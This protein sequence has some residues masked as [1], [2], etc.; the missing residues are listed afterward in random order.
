MIIWLASYPKSGNTWVRS[1]I[2][3]LAYSNDGKF[4]MK[5]LSQIHQFPRISQLKDIDKFMKKNGFKAV[6]KSCFKRHETG[7]YYDVLYEKNKIN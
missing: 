5:L 2:T 4:E 6:I 3:A 1:I 7:N